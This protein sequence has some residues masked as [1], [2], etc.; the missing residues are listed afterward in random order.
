[1]NNFKRF[2]SDNQGFY[3]IVDD[4]L[5]ICLLFLVFTSFNTMID[6]A[7]VNDYDN[8]I[9]NYNQA[10]DIMEIMS[11]SDDSILYRIYTNLKSSNNSAEAYRDS[12]IMADN[13]FNNSLSDKNY[14]FYI[15][16]YLLSSKGNINPDNYNSA[17]RFIGDYRFLLIV[18][19]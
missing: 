8:T 12:H 1:M 16:D 4:I 5:A 11:S 19:N 3:Y 9:S 6:I 17:K 14:R 2:K 10:E 7:S 13:F 18:G 15:N